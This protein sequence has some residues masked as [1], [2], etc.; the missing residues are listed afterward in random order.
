MEV[1][2][3]NKFSKERDEM[4]VEGVKVMITPPINEE[5][6]LFR[7]KLTKKQGI[8]AFPKFGTYGIGFQV[9]EKDWNTN[10]PYQSSAEDIYNHI[11]VNKGDE[12]I[13]ELSCI[14]AIKLLQIAIR[15]FRKGESIQ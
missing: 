7:V 13:S 8:V 4:E 1:M 2:I 6:W 15:D 3:N 10:L 11:S 14:L 5:Y 9:E 12:N